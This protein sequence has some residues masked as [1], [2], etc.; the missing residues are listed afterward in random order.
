[1]TIKLIV[2]AQHKSIFSKELTELGVQHTYH[3]AE[4][5]KFATFRIEAYTPKRQKLVFKIYNIYK[6]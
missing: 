1:M 3:Y 2:P 6:K 4:G 5:S